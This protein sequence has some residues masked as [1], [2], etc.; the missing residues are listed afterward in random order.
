V[1]VLLVAGVD[2]ALPGGLETHVLELA[3]GLAARG[4]D[5]DVHGRASGALPAPAPRLVA[6]VDLARYDVVHHHGGAWPRAWDAGPRY[7]RT[8]HFSVAAKMAVYLRMGRIRTLFNPG[9]HRAL[10]EERGALRR[11]ALQI[12]VSRSLRDDLVR[13]HGARR[14]SIRVVPNGASF[15]A[16]A[17]GRDAWRARHGIGPT[18]PLLLTIGRDDFVK[19]TDLLAR[20]W[21]RAALPPGAIWVRVG[22]ARAERTADRLTTGP[23]AADDVVAWIGAADAGAL[24]SYY[25]GGAIAL[26]DMLAGGLYVLT[27]AVGVAPEAV[28]PGENG[29]FVRR[30]AAAWAAALESALAAPAPR[31]GAGLPA[32][33]SWEAMTGRVE[34]VYA[35]LRARV[36]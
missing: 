25:E 28:R 13:F 17:F 15:A 12:A 26:T 19:G 10:H 21:T 33:W 34:S 29:E 6:E 27:H 30:D 20:A 8:F 24:P 4:H 31:R 14:E 22:G 5:V 7:L 35:E 18:A 9:N 2:L 3:R 23:I 1:N 11:G 36:G 32:E 16:P